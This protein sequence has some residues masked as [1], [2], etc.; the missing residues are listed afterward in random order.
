[1]HRCSIET[2]RGMIPT[3]REHE[4]VPQVLGLRWTLKR[5]LWVIEL[6]TSMWSISGV[7]NPFV[8]CTIKL[9]EPSEEGVSPPRGSPLCVKWTLL[10]CS[11]QIAKSGTKKWVYRW[12]KSRLKKGKL[13]WLDIMGYCSVK[14]TAKRYLIS[15][16][17]F[18]KTRQVFLWANQWIIYF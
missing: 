6:F 16:L 14:G 2:L 18:H 12:K 10:H 17:V 3:L 7:G 8:Y 13:D 9:L 1:M 5:L 4:G 11:H 15:L